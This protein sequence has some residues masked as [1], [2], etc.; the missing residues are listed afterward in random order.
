[1]QC[2]GELYHLQVNVYTNQYRIFSLKIYLLAEEKNI[3]EANR[4]N[5]EIKEKVTDSKGNKPLNP[6][7][8]FKTLCKFMLK[9]YIL[10]Y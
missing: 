9:K 1:M 3:E 4:K 7:S 10:I 5:L 8:A 6:P 2:T